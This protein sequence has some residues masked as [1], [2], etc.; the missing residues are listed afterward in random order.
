VRNRWR[1]SKQNSP[2]SRAV[3]LAFYQQR[4][5]VLEEIEVMVEVFA[6]SLNGVHHVASRERV[7]VEA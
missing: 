5:G 3:H 1:I 6:G 4:V 7:A 2:P